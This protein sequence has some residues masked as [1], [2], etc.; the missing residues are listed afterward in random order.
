MADKPISPDTAPRI[1]VGVVQANS[2]PDMHANMVRLE[3]AIR[4]AAGKGAQLV[5]LPET[6]HIM[7]MNRERLAASV[8]D[9][10]HDEGLAQ[11][12]ALA[13]ELQIYLHVGSLIVRAAGGK[14]AN[15][16][17]FIGPDGHI[18]AR[19]DK[20]HLF[21]VEL[22]GGEHY[23]E[24]AHF[25][26]GRRAVTVEALGVKFGLS[27][28]YDVR[29]PVLYRTLA[30]E[31][32]KVLMVPAA[33]T[34]PTGEAHWHSLL[35]ARAIENGAYVIAAAQTGANGPDGRGGVRKT[36][37]HSLVVSPWGDVLLDAGEEPG[38]HIVDLDMAEVAKA[39]SRI[40]SL[41]HDRP[42]MIN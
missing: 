35:R 18:D 9:E 14:Y 15:R 12:C 41:T 22:D 37:G 19:Y 20:I 13:R 8:H 33:F 16:T 32:A 6:A 39:R 24:S 29:F 36:Y 30:S 4:S 26:P 7:D 1:A 21:D 34:R 38:V 23:K 3:A 17:F 42:F 28:C 31:G 5:S 40:P 10:E 2:G 11:L 27:I 25:E